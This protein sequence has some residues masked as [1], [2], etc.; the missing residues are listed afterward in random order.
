MPGATLVVLG[1]EFGGHADAEGHC[2]VEGLPPGRYDLQCSHI[3][4]RSHTVHAVS[5]SAQGQV[6]ALEP[7]AVEVPGVVVSAVRRAQTFAQAPIS[8]AV[9]DA[10][11]I[12]DHNAFSLVVPL[13]YVSGISQVGDQLNI[14][15]SSGFSR[16]TGSRILM[17]VDGF[18]LLA[19]DLGD[20]KWDAVPLHQ[21]ERVEVIKGAGS[22]L[23]GT[24][25]LGG[26]I[27]V[28]TRD[29]ARKPGTR[30]R[31]LSGLY[32]PPAHRGWRWTE[33]S[34]HLAGFDLSHNRVIGRTAVAL[35]GGHNRG[36]GYHQNGDGRR[37][38]T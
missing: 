3:G 30:F 7:S 37:T 20:I 24:G 18:P 12:A 16:G 6:I 4:Y 21:V 17:L 28:L 9:A 33:G 31:L 15:G 32:S 26:V 10:R 36:T 34:M 5:T 29:P 25:A 8:I 38:W 11:R 13:R 35:S 22:A 14:R 27:N 19:A 23:Y 2:R 1:T